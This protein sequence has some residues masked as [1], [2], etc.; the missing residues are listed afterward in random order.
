[1]IFATSFALLGLILPE[2]ERG[3]ALGTNIA[4]SF[5]GFALGFLGGG[6]FTYYTTWRVLFLVPLPV[7]LLAIGILRRNLPGECALSRGTRPDLPGIVLSTTMILLIMV[8]SPPCRGCRAP[9]PLS[10]A[11]RRSPPSSSMKPE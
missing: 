8:D 7:A 1:M 5:G 2:S 3:A 4:A 10:P 11:S 6:L 9:S